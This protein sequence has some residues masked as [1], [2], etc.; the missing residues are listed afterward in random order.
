V[1]S[2]RFNVVRHAIGPKIMWSVY[3]SANGW[4]SH[5]T[6]RR[7]ARQACDLARVQAWTRERLGA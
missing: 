1:A 3:D 4:V 5:H 2:D 6:T 7:E